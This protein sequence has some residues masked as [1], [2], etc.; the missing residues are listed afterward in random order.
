MNAVADSARLRDLLW[1]WLFPLV[2]ALLVSAISIIEGSLAPR[3]SMLIRGFGRMPDA[4]LYQSVFA[5]GFA[6]IL[7]YG[8]SRAFSPLALVRLLLGLAAFTLANFVP[9]FGGL[10]RVGLVV[11]VLLLLTFVGA[12]LVFFVPAATVG[13]IY[14][15]ALWVGLAIARGDFSTREPSKSFGTMP[16][17]TACGAIVYFLGFLLEGALRGQQIMPSNAIFHFG[18]T[19]VILIVSCGICIFLGV[20]QF[21][22]GDAKSFDRRSLLICGGAALACVVGLAAGV[23]M[24]TMPA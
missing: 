5:F 9:E 21:A 15:I 11:G 20:W 23:R 7:G 17:A 19:A 4:F 2:A 13:A 14:G 8:L 12:P 6:S 10:L 24:C 1:L 22:R 18:F 16:M 3:G